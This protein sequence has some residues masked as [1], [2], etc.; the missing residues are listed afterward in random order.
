MLGGV[1]KHCSQYPLI[2]AEDC[3][4]SDLTADFLQHGRVPVRRPELMAVE[5]T[6]PD[7]STVNVP[8]AQVFMGTRNLGVAGNSNRILKLFMDSGA[9]HLCLCNDDLHVDGDFVEF[10]AKAHQDLGVGMFCFCVAGDTPLLTFNGITSLQEASGKTV[11]VW[12]GEGWKTVCPRRTGTGQKLFRVNLSDGSFLDCTGEHGFSVKTRGS[13]V[14]KR[15]M[16]RD[17]TTCFRKGSAV[18]CEPVKVESTGGKSANDAYTLGFAVGDGH[19]A[20]VKRVGTVYN[21]T[22]I[23]LYGAKKKCPVQGKRYPEPKRKRVRVVCALNPELVQNLKDA[24]E[25]LDTLF[26]WKRKSILEFVAG[27]ADADGTV[28]AS[29]SI[30]ITLSGERRARK[31]Q[32]LLTRAGIKSSIGIDGLAGSSTNFGLRS[33][34]QWYITIP[35]CRQIPCHRLDVSRGHVSRLKYQ[36]VRSVEA[37][38]GLHDVYCFSEPDKH[39]G[40][41]ANVLTYQCDFV[42]ASPAISGHPDSYKWTVYPW[43][44]Y[45]LKFLPRFTGIMISVTRALLEKVGYFDAVFTQFGEEH[46]DF[47]VRCRMAGGIRVDQQ[48]MNCLDVEHALLRHQDVP[49]SVTGLARQTADREASIIMGQCA[50]DYVYTHYHRPFRLKQPRLCGGYRGGGIPFKNLMDA[51]YQL[52]TDLDCAGVE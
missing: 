43:R 2:I 14:F 35:D 9:D 51:G 4:Q 28:T 13:S 44:G 16:A 46:S 26:G 22:H 6:V 45:K 12:N 33:R 5:Y 23:Y 27:L 38:P 19:W 41:F 48:D 3:G 1:E 47:T 17:L 30:R 50:R 42:A 39:K 25:S 15:V 8:N 18:Q 40:L 10:Y 34:D 32:M 37:L 20:K 29:G 24:P 11:R 52:V 31:L 7:V 36:T 49:T 21:Y